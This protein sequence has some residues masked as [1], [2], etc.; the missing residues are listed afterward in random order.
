MLLS[1]RFPELFQQP[2]QNPLRTSPGI[3]PPNQVPPSSQMR[4]APVQPTGFWDAISNAAS[5]GWNTDDLWAAMED[6]DYGL[7]AREAVAI[8]NAPPSAEFKRIF[9]PNNGTDNFSSF[10]RGLFE[11]PLE[12]LQAFAE[13]QIEQV[14]RDT[15]LYPINVGV[16][17]LTGVIGGGVGSAVPAVGTAAGYVGGRLAGTFATSFVTSHSRNQAAKLQEL[18]E[19]NGVNL[20]DPDSIRAAFSDE[21]TIAQLQQKAN[22]YG[23]ANSLTESFFNTIS[24][25]IPV[26]KAKVEVFVFPVG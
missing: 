6:Q 1:E 21:Q 5:R 4:S 3:T 16:P 8:H 11:H 26:F 14:A 18:L 15:W 20:E 2:Q 17:L 12:T 24:M 25:G 22:K 9:E 7:M 23:L 13:M 19:A 10:I